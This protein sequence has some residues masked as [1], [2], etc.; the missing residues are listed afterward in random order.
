MF[1]YYFGKWN[2]LIFS[3]RKFLYFR[4]WNFKAPRLKSFKREFSVLGKLK[5]NAL[6]FFFF[7]LEIGFSSLKLKKNSHIFRKE[8]AKPGKQKFQNDG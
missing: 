5:K 3:Q 4:K 6:N 8:L 7:F 1:F 2:L